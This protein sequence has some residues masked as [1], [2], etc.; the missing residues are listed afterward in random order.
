MLAFLQ[1]DYKRIDTEV[2]LEQIL[3]L[4]PSKMDTDGE[5]GLA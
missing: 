2:F 5:T 1:V 3:Y 4:F